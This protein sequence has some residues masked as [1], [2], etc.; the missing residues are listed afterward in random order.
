MPITKLI[1]SSESSLGMTIFLSF[2]LSIISFL[3]KVKMASL[4]GGSNLKS[5]F[6]VVGLVPPKLT[7]RP[8]T[9]DCQSNS[10]VSASCGS[11]IS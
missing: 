8:A 4:P 5:A 7:Y 9:E 2:A 10:T 11:Q 6:F 1:S 3:L